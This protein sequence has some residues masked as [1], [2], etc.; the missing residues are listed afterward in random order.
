MSFQAFLCVCAHVSVVSCR[1]VY[2]VCVCVRVRCVCT[3]VEYWG[4]TEPGW[5]VCAS[6]GLGREV[7][8][9]EVGVSKSLLAHLHALVLLRAFVLHLRLLLNRHH[10]SKE[11]KEK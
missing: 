10:N 5:V 11:E 6:V 8:V 1:V 2:T 7:P 4:G 3:Q 9:V